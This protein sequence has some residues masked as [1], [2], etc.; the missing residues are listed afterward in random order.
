ML[1]Y[2][3]T[4]SLCMCETKIYGGE[5]GQLQQYIVRATFS[6]FPRLSH[7]VLPRMSV[8]VPSLKRNYLLK[9]LP[10]WAKNKI[11]NFSQTHLKFVKKLIFTF[12]DVLS[13]RRTRISRWLGRENEENVARTRNYCGCPSSPRSSNLSLKYQKFTPTGFKNI[14]I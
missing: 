12:N 8:N 9:I 1:T 6:S 3:W 7:M 2:N 14:G 10:H 11:S 4:I 5:D 13:V